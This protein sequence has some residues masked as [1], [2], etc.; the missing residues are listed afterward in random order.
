MNTKKAIWQNAIPF[1]VIQNEN[2][3]LKIDAKKCLWYQGTI[4]IE[5]QLNPRHISNYAMICMRYKK[6]KNNYTDILINYGNEGGKMLSENKLFNKNAIVGLNREFANAIYE[7][8]R[9]SQLNIPSGSIEIIGGAYDVAGSSNYAF[10][11]AM[12]LL[13]Y[14]FENS[15]NINDKTIGDELLNRI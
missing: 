15:K 4:C 1:E 14:I 9:E 7:F 12:D 11:K 3:K 5:V 13:I 6:N 10:K 8:F 2:I